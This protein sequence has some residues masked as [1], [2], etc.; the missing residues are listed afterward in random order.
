MRCSVKMG[1][2]FQGAR[3]GDGL[4][5]VTLRSTPGSLR[6]PLRGIEAESVYGV[7]RQHGVRRAV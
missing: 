4:P 3:I 5:G 7:A 2:R 6:M 1:R